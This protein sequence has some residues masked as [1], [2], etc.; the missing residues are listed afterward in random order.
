MLTYDAIIIGAGLSGLSAAVSMSAHREIRLAVVEAKGVGSNNPSPLT[1][2]GAMRDYGLADCL[3]AK[4]TSFGYHNYQGSVIRYHFDG[5]PLAVL[6][7][8]KACRKLF[9]KV[10]VS[11]KDVDIFNT[12]AV[13]VGYEDDKVCVRL[14]SGE[15]LG[16]K[17]LIDCSG[18]SKMVHRLFGDAADGFHSHVYG[19]Q[20]AASDGVDENTAYFLWPNPEFGTGGG[21]FYP[22]D[23]GRISFGYAS[24]SNE[25][26]PQESSIKNGFMLAMKHFKPYS[27]HLRRAQLEHIERGTIPISY[28]SRRVYPKILIAGDAAAMATN[29]TC[30]GVEPALRYGEMAGSFALRAI[31]SGTMDHIEGFQR[32]WEE[33][34]KKTHDGFNQLAPVFWNADFDTWEWI[35]KN[36]LAFLTPDQIV[37]RM[38]WNRHVP[39]KA[40]FTLRAAR[41][42]LQSIFDQRM[43]APR[44]IDIHR[45]S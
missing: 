13:Q 14:Y 25:D 9:N 12:E 34:N 42:K 11:V 16:S 4:Y 35:I 15:N 19:G 24:I 36:D 21:W 2:M 45:C 33:E 40:K 43:L 22:M 20:F 10:A 27:S 32:C 38:R 3:K 7:Y 1:F 6:D 30:M 17:V 26:R 28:V 5:A 18:K 31:L 29:W 8:K 37:G 23:N 41:F 39:S 44:V